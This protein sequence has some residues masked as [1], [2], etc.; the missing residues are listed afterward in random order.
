MS[1]YQYHEF[2]AIDRS[3]TDQQMRELR[4]ISTRAAI[5]RTSFSNYYTFGDLKAN[6]RDLLT[7][8]FDASLYFANWLFLEVAFRY[9]K[10]AVAVKALR[11]YAAGHTL[12]I[13]RS[14]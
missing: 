6:P 4:A 7:K 12:E 11:R 2:R 5:S 8:Y 1:E 13:L 3:L 14:C 9:P 10:V